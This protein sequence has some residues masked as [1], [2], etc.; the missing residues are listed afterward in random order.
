MISLRP[1]E[2]RGQTVIWITAQGKSGLY[3]QE[4]QVKSEIQSLIGA[5]IEVMG[6]DLF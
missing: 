2:W 3:E 1:A 6:I 5:G 4:G